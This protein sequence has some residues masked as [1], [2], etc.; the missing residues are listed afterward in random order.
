MRKI[1][2]LALTTILLWGCGHQK[3]E[4]NTFNVGV[5]LPLSGNLSF[6]GNPEKNGFELA[7]SNFNKIHKELKINL[8]FED[9]KSNA[10]DAVN[11][12]Q[13]LIQINKV[14]AIIVANT[15][16]NLAIAPIT[17]KEKILHI[18]FCMEPEIQN[19]HSLLYRLYESSIQEG[20]A[21]RD[22][23]LEDKTK[24]K[25][26]AFLYIDQPNFVKT[27][28][29]VIKPGLLNNSKIEMYFEKYKLDEVSFVPV[30]TKIKSK[31]VDALVLLGYGSEYPKLFNQMTELGIRN[32]IDI[33]G[34]WGFL[35]PQ[36]DV[37]LLEGVKVAAPVFAI[38]ENEVSQAF[39]SDFSDQFKY[40]PNFDAAF[41]NAALSILLHAYKNANSNNPFEISKNIENNKFDTP[42]GNVEIKNRELI[43]SMG[44]GVYRN[45]ELIFK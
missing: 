22:Y 37:K 35:Y 42:I 30:L 21:I 29:D 13:K 18:A 10:N 24:Y 41:A 7:L 33:I 15:G 2:Y 8:I 34:G 38:S 39:K 9:S 11:A 20:E 25:K 32:S 44:I 14:N 26:I 28:E 19:N 31:Q 40:K 1:I 17:E 36:M 45:G 27:V 6:M 4:V 5:I 23:L 43:V 12:A 3:K 16:P